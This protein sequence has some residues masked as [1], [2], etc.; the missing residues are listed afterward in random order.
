LTGVRYHVL[1]VLVLVLVV[2]L[3]VL[4]LVLVLVVELLVLVVELLVLV[5]V[6]VLVPPLDPEEESRRL[7]VHVARR[8][9]WS[10][11]GSR[12]TG[13]SPLPGARTRGPLPLAPPASHVTGTVL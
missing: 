10:L 9:G 1:L 3:L 6:L 7:G 8:P 5:L 13:L 2:E 11:D 12:R 4:V